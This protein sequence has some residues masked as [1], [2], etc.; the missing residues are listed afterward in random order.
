MA[1]FAVT[2]DELAD[3]AA[4]ELLWTDQDV[5]R[6]IKPDAVGSPPREL[7]LATSYADPKVYIFRAANADNIVEKLLYGEKL[8]LN[9]LI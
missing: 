6:G 1:T 7:S 3:V 5:Q 2:A 9:P 8:F 4:N